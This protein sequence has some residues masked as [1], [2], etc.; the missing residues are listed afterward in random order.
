MNA[1]HNLKQQQA[2]VWH[3]ADAGSLI[4]ICY[5]KLDD[6]LDAVNVRLHRAISQAIICSPTHGWL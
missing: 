1:D 4:A 2:L 6:S 3:W 5:V